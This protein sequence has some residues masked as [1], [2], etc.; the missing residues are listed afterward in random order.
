MGGKSSKI[1]D[2]TVHENSSLSSM[3]LKNFK[4][5]IVGDH[6]V[7]KSS[8]FRRYL[9]NT[10]TMDYN[11][12]NNANIGIRMIE[13]ENYDPCFLELWDI[14][15][16]IDMNEKIVQNYL[17]KIDGFIFVYSLDSRDSLDIATN[18]Y[19][20][21]L[22]QK[23]H[24]LNNN[25]LKIPSIIIGNKSDTVNEYLD[26]KKKTLN[27][28]KVISLRANHWAN[29]MNIM[30][31]VVSAKENIEIHQTIKTFAHILMKSKA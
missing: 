10:F 16:I 28:G 15:H 17:K 4:I 27:K 21:E 1:D 7:G 29:G 5:L 30:H 2:I 3:N 12:D 11:N 22:Y 19:Y 13:L 31:K 18:Y 25:N 26:S 8:I 14:P 24:E 23:I 6:K 9:S 20:K